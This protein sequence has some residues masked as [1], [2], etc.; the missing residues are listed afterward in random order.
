M[1]FDEFGGV[2]LLK[3]KVKYKNFLKNFKN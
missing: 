2:I 1:V 3:K